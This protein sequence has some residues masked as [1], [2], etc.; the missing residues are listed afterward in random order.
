MNRIPKTYDKYLEKQE[1]GGRIPAPQLPVPRTYEEGLKNLRQRVANVNLTMNE[2]I[3]KYMKMSRRLFY[4]HLQKGHLRYT[5]ILVIAR[6][7]RLHP[8][9]YMCHTA[10]VNEQAARSRIMR[11]IKRQRKI[12][13]NR[14]GTATLR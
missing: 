11:S 1:G 8:A 12:K 2:F 10:D 13:S 4:H 5:K 7:L 3:D 14:N 6:V 9:E